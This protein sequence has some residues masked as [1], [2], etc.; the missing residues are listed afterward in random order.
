M[1]WMVHR[2]NHRRRVLAASTA[3]CVAAS[4]WIRLWRKSCHAF[5]RSAFSPPIPTICSYNSMGHLSSASTIAGITFPS[6]SK[7]YL[8]SAH[9]SQLPSGSSSPGTHAVVIFTSPRS[10]AA[11]NERASDAA[12]PPRSSRAGQRKGASSHRASP[13]TATRLRQAYLRS[14]AR[15]R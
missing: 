2:R 13:T 9:R 4:D 7:Q 5:A 6:G 14:N 12:G 1:S 10:R 11:A 8:D 15:D 3:C